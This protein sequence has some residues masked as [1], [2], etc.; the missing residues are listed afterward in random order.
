MINVWHDCD[1][2]HD[3]AIALLYCLQ[4]PTINIWWSSTVH[5][6]QLAIKT[7]TNAIRILYISGNIEK[8]KQ[9]PV[10]SGANKPLQRE[11]QICPEIHGE[12][13]LGGVNW[14]EIDKKIESLG[15]NIKKIQNNLN[16]VNDIEKVADA[17][18]NAYK[19][20][21]NGKLTLLVTGCHTNIAHF[22]KKYPDDVKSGNINIVAMGGCIN[23]F[24]NT[25]PFQEFNIQID[26]E[27]FDFV[28]KSFQSKKSLVTLIPLEVTHT[29]LATKEILEKL[30][31]NN[32]EKIIKKLLLFFKDTY[33]NVFH[34][35]SPPVH[36]PVAPYY[37]THP[38]NFKV[39]HYKAVVET[40]G[41]Y[42]SGCICIHR[43]DNVTSWCDEKEFSDLDVCLKVDINKFWETMV[44]YLHEIAKKSP[45]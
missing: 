33:K 13:G 5:G 45:I 1:P 32:F 24:G 3:D 17:I 27:A 43:Y 11:S 15:I 4:D 25:G 22:A 31:N 38:E 18:H 7:Y 34:F 26:P 16:N 44:E 37:I 6:N 29:V 23:T 19:N 14:S 39:E 2:G 41:K 10:L 30:Q 20:S 21:N 40:K 42:T 28:L 8:I 12:T 35:E 9:I 36:D